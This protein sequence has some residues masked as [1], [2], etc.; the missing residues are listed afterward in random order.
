MEEE[1]EEEKIS[2]IVILYQDSKECTASIWPTKALSKTLLFCKDDFEKEKNTKYS[3]TTYW[4]PPYVAKTDYGNKN[5]STQGILRRRR[6]QDTLEPNR[7]IRYTK[8]EE[9]SP[10]TKTRCK[11]ERILRS[12][13]VV[14]RESHI[15]KV[16]PPKPKEQKRDVDVDPGEY[17][18]YKYA[19]TMFRKSKRIILFLEKEETDLEIPVFG[20]F[21]EREVEK[22]GGYLEV[23]SP[24]I[25]C[26]LYEIRTTPSKKK[27][28]LAALVATKSSK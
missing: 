16:P 27:G 28:R 23:Y 3:T 8:W 25:R 15:Q 1:E 4:F 7:Y 5:T 9:K 12:A 26:R 17:N 19:E 10:S 6:V 2:R 14:D 11:N 13:R 22:L 20:Y 21:L 24:P 18:C